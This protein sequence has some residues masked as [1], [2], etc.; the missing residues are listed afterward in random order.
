MVTNVAAINRL[1]AGGDG[2]ARAVVL[3]N[4]AAAIMAA[5]LAPSLAEGL[6]LAVQAIDSGAAA[7]RVARLIR[8]TREFAA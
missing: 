5:G 3:L 8:L 7:D 2:P 4:A 6:P 1:F